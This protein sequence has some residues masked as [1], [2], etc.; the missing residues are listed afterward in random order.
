[1]KLLTEPLETRGDGETCLCPG[2]MQFYVAVGILSGK[3]MIFFSFYLCVKNVS[4][5]FCIDDQISLYIL[6]TAQIICI[7]F[8]IYVNS[9]DLFV[10]FLA[11]LFIQKCLTILVHTSI[12]SPT[13]WLHFQQVMSLARI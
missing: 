10:L 9:C 8:L 13:R 6:L 2:F 1:M 7:S 3:Y 11:L 5:A 4:S 12:I